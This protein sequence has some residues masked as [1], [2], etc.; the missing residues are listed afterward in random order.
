MISRNWVHT[1]SAII[2]LG[3]IYH[4]SW[5]D[6]TVDDIRSRNAAAQAAVATLQARVEAHTR[7][8]PAKAPKRS[9]EKYERRY[10]IEYARSGDK[11]RHKQTEGAS[12]VIDTI[13]DLGTGKASS[14]TPKTGGRTIDQGS[15]STARSLAPIVQPW[16]WALFEL[17]WCNKPLHKLLGE[18]EATA[19]KMSLAPGGKLIRLDIRSAGDR[20]EVHVDPSVN[21]LVRKVVA[22]RTFPKVT[23]REEIEILDVQEVRPGVFFP[24]AV[25]LTPLGDGTWMLKGELTFHDIRVNEK[26]PADMFR[27][28]FPPGTRVGDSEKKTTYTVGGDGR[29]TAVGTIAP[30]PTSPVAEVKTS[31]PPTADDAWPWHRYVFVGSVAAVAVGLGLLFWKRRQP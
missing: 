6:T 23:A 9:D 26:L 17:P 19:V 1:V 3:T 16:A 18:T 14:F 30:P 12:R 13:R 7:L 15:I 25:M 2:T 11:E 22:E 10:V 21:Y 24:N 29:P 28:I 31:T 4:G 27:R 5:G 8:N 20:Y